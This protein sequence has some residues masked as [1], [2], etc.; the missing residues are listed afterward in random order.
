MYHIL[1]YNRSFD[2]YFSRLL[3]V[4]SHFLCS[5]SLSFHSSCH[6]ITQQRSPDMSV[7]MKVEVAFGPI[8]NILFHNQL[9]SNMTNDEWED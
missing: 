1:S 4:F 7:P 6:H 8:D 5:H 9:L 3:G 2:R